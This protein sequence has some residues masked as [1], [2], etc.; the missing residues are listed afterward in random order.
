[1]NSVDWLQVDP[2]AA[3]AERAA[4]RNDFAAG[5]PLLREQAPMRTLATM[6]RSFGVSLEEARQAWEASRD[7]LD[8]WKNGTE[9]LPR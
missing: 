3:A 7:A 1:M 8:E 4:P 9:P 6:A 2:V 5:R